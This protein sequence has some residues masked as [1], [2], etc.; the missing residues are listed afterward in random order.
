MDFCISCEVRLNL[1]QELLALFKDND[2]SLH[3]ASD[4]K[5]IVTD[6]KRQTLN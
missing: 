3:R 5:T 6:S 1:L 2:S 4:L